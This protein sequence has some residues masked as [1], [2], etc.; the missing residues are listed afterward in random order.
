MNVPDT[1]IDALAENQV[2]SRLDVLRANL[3]DLAQSSDPADGVRG[4]P[5][6][7]LGLLPATAARPGAPRRSLTTYDN[8]TY[9]PL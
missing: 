1:G 7:L 5:P 6:D 2:G 9:I 4:S 8:R 3:I